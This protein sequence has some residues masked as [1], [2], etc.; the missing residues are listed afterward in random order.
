VERTLTDA[1]VAETE[2]TIR[3]FLPGLVPSIVRSDSFPDLFTPDRRPLIGS[4]PGRP[5]T[6][7]ATGFSGKGF[8]ISS[9]VGSLI[10]RQALG[11]PIHPD[12]EG[13]LGFADPGRF[14]SM[15]AG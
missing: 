13:T 7:L 15:K 10:A 5:R 8:K 14:A 3:E 1:E 2:L 12:L 4:V 11:D 9:G 6:F